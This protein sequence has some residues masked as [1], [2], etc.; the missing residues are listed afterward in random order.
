MECWTV[1]VISILVFILLNIYFWIYCL[2]CKRTKR[3]GDIE[4]F[5][6]VVHK[7]NKTDTNNR[8]YLF[9]LEVYSESPSD[10]AD[11]RNSCDADDQN[12]CDADDQ[13]SWEYR[14]RRDRLLP[15]IPEEEPS[16]PDEPEEVED[17]PEHIQ[18][19]AD[20]HHHP[21]PPPQLPLP[22]PPPQ[23]SPTGDEHFYNVLDPDTYGEHFDMPGV[24][25]E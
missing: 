24:L 19:Q 22:P 2:F 14:R 10:D 18:I 25:Y 12:L 13:N 4:Y 8:K 9:P 21:P 1:I 16:I 17:E 7:N 15:S 6:T 23:L 3:C 20:I 5:V 11:D